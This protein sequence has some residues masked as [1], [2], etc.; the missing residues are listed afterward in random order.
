MLSRVFNKYLSLNYEVRVLLITTFASGVFDGLLY[1]GGLLQ[2]Y[3]KSAGYGGGDVGLFIFINGLVSSILVIP[4]G[5]LADV[6]GRRRI[7]LISAIP[8]T[9]STILI[10]VSPP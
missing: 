1:M 7:A 6:F 9:I 10:A 8:S 2:L 5:Y 4:S 3:L